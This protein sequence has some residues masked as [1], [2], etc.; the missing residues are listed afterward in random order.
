MLRAG[1][2]LVVGLTL[3]LPALAGQVPAPRSPEEE[4]ARWDRMFAAEPAHIRWEPN[5]FVI[6]VAPTLRVGAAIDVG[7]G[8]GRNALYLARSGWQVTGVDTSAVGV[9][10]ARDRAAEN[11]LPLTAVQSDMFAFDYGT[12]RYDLVL[13][14]YMGPVGDLG[15]R[16]VRALKPG[17]HLLIEHF[18]GG[19][20]AGSLSTLFKGLT[21]LRYSEDEDFP[22]Y[23][24]RTKGRVVRYLARKPL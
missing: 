9:E 19:F 14:M 4:R 20:E 3:V 6:E 22:D 10:R 5:R 7:M 15:E 24:L 1:A 18:A 21:V 8:S 2:L 23:D 16:F 11:K 13:F 17:G 12:D